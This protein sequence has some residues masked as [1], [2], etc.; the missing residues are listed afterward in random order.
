MKEQRAFP[1]ILIRPYG[2]N[3]KI[4]ANQRR[5]IEIEYQCGINRRPAF[6]LTEKAECSGIFSL[7]ENI[8]SRR[9]GTFFKPNA[10]QNI[11]I[12]NFNYINHE[13]LRCLHRYFC[14]FHFSGA[15]YACSSGRNRHL[16]LCAI[17]YQPS[18]MVLIEYI[19]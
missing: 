13:V 16:S 14:S 2:A 7:K 3:V 17:L 6:Q 11:D 8:K 9:H 12:Y 10:F 19:F 4:H 18:I 15:R 1:A 5:W